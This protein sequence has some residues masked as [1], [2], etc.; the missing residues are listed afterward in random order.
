MTLT[1]YS[2]AVG[3]AMEQASVTIKVADANALPAVAMMVV[4]EDGDALD[5]QPTSVPEGESVM[6]AVM[7]VDKDGDA[8]RRRRGT[9][10]RV[11]ADWH[12]RCGG[13]Y[14]GGDVHH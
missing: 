11:D 10:G 3:R 7:P 1:A 12:G 4:D 6:V 13:L 2:G 5:P 14:V 8:D 9:Q